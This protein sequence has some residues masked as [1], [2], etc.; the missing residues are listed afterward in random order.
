MKG[1]KYMY[2]DYQGYEQET[3]LLAKP[4]ERQIYEERANI[5]TNCINLLGIDEPLPSYPSRKGK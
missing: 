1:E 5:R 3:L 2:E 4:S